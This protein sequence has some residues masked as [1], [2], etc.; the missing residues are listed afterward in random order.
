MAQCFI[1]TNQTDIA[2]TLYKKALALSQ[3]DPV[4]YYKIGDL[5]LSH[6]EAEMLLNILMKR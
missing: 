1:K 2:L 4:L 6:G 3:E 5:Y